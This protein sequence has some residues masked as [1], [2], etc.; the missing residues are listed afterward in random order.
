VKERKKKGGEG[1]DARSDD[2]HRGGVEMA[3]APSRLRKRGGGGALK[4]DL[5]NI[6]RQGERRLVEK[7]Q[8][9]EKRKK[10]RQ[11]RKKGRPELS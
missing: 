2:R 1:V 4:L 11:K 9:D 3:E 8:K 10:G 5:Q 7:R 6:L